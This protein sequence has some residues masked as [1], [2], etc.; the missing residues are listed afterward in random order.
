MKKALI[1]T[2]TGVFALTCVSAFMWAGFDYSWWAPMQ[3]GSG[4]GPT[5]WFLH[6][7]GLVQFAIALGLAEA[8]KYPHP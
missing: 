6:F 7:M 1:I 5:L 3:A 4:R 2:S 8:Q